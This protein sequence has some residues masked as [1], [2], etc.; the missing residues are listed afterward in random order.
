MFEIS[1]LAFL[2]NAIDMRYSNPIDSVHSSLTPVLYLL[3][4]LPYRTYSPQQ[5]AFT[6]LLVYHRDDILKEYNEYEDISVYAQESGIG[7]G[8]DLL[9]N[10]NNNNNNNSNNK[11]QHNILNNHTNN[12]SSNHSNSNGH[13]HS[14]SGGPTSASADL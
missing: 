9:G 7:S 2:R 4:L 12:H 11:N 14:H 8:S 13:S 5:L 1:F 3:H 6:A 10:Q